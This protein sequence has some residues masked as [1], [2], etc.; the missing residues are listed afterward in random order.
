MSLLLL[1]VTPMIYAGIGSRQ[2]PANIINI[3]KL[4]AELLAYDGHTCSTGAC[5][6][7]DQAF[8]EGAL[9]GNGNL[10]LHLPW[11]NYERNWI[12]SI[13]G[14]IAINVL[15]NNNPDAYR[16]VNKYHPNA[17]KLSSGAIKLH[18]RNYL[19]ME[20]ADFVICWTPNGI[21]SGGTGQAL[22]MAADKGIK[23]FNLG[24]DATLKAFMYRINERSHEIKR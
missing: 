18:A 15:R 8:A 7:A 2:T 20:N 21:T 5:K 6:G 14:N 22:R 17:S 11:G 10:L 23:V 4:I 24:D 13:T 3:I 19:I 12:N 16:S 1:E 9:K